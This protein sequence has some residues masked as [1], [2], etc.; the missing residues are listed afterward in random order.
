MRVISHL[1]QL[2]NWGLLS[3][4]SLALLLAGCSGGDDTSSST[5]D[6]NSSGYISGYTVSGRV[7]VA[8]NLAKDNDTNDPNAPTTNSNN[9]LST[10]QAIPNPSLVGGYVSIAGAGY[11]GQLRIAGD[12]SDFYSVN[13]LKGQ[14]ISLSIA[15]ANVRGIDLDLYLYSAGKIADA[16]VNS[17]INENLTVRSSGAYIIEVRAESGYANYVLSLGQDVSSTA[18]AERGARLSDD[19][20]VGEYIVKLNPQNELTAQA[21]ITALNSEGLQTNSFDSS[22]RMLFTEDDTQLKLQSTQCDEFISQEICDKYHTLQKL[23]T[24]QAYSQVTE[25]SPN[26]ILQA[27]RVPNDPLLKYQWHYDLINVPQA[28]DLTLG[29]SNVIV[30]VID[31]GVLLNHPDLAGKTVAGY[32]FV[33]SISTSKD[34]DGIDSNPNDPGSKEGRES[35]S[36]FHGTH[37]AGT[38]GASTNNGAGI[39]GVG[40]LT[41]IMPLRVLGRGGAGKEYDAEQAVRFA[42]GLSNDSKTVPVKRADIINLSLG[43]SQISTGFKDAITSARNNGVVI[44]AAAGNDGSN[45]PS[46][47]AALDGVISVSAVNI[48]K[49]LAYYSN[50]GNTID[51]AAP[52]GDK[53]TPDVDGDGNT[54]QIASTYG[55]D[56]STTI[57]YNYYY[58]QGTSMATPHVA[59]VIA[60][61]KAVNPNLTPNMIDSLL[62][63]GKI[64]DDIGATGKDTQF[65]YGLINAQKA[66]LVASEGTGNISQSSPLLVASPTSANFG[67][68]Q[69]RLELHLANSGSGSVRVGT[70]SNDS[71]GAVSVSSYNVDS[72]GLGTYIIQ[73]N[74]TNLAAGTY[75]ATININSDVN[76]VRIPVIFQVAAQNQGTTG[77][78]G[79]HYILL[80]DADTLSTVQE[81]RV[82]ATNGYYNYKFTNVPS[83][84]YQLIVGT[85][86]DND[87]FICGEAEA[88]GS[89]LTLDNPNTITLSR[90]TTLLDF[91]TGYNSGFVSYSSENETPKTRGYARLSTQQTHQ[92]SP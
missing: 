14:T 79:Y 50:Y 39:A 40:W 52:G 66:V 37:V 35:S 41:Q 71:G 73:V 8:S 33:S 2:K 30:A 9:S 21:T 24:I 51:V 46:Y 77:D 22:R 83:G 31:T 55:D 70:I 59:G 90:S 7:S 91:A 32:D 56:S 5:E 82:N 57:D 44:V 11:S 34:G 61:M 36:T 88:C 87:G 26:Y 58:L 48:N 47:P 25:A 29:S 16:S 10:A 1:T 27:F 89:Y 76:T 17:G 13:L 15:N 78:A 75:N 86:S 67:F 4:C 49:E 85:D 80:V 60:L 3:L 53:S 81:V 72:T 69:T 18:T 45:D 23:K 63:S 92:V 12:V 54:D 74:R 65:G 62:T 20:A 68:T 28:W 6:D 38:I 64:T 43:G 19:F 84:T 42:A